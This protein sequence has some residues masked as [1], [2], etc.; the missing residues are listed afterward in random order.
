MEAYNAEF[1]NDNIKSLDTAGIELKRLGNN[2]K[3]AFVE[4]N[5]ELK[6]FGNEVEVA[7]NKINE[8][9][10]LTYDA[11][12][13]LNDS[14]EPFNMALEKNGDEA[15]VTFVFDKESEEPMSFDKDAVEAFI[16]GS[17]Q[18]HLFGDEAINTLNSVCGKIENFDCN[19]IK[20]FEAASVELEFKLKIKFE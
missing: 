20:A 5:M 13:V 16:T 2:A 14:T 19:D 11:T 4:G 17:G 12:K 9:L 6:K 3:E 18:I 7:L 15:K 8:E 1:V 10:R